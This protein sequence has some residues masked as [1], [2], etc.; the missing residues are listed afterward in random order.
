METR[1]P[2][3]S[4]SDVQ[5]ILTEICHWKIH[6]I[7]RLDSFEDRNFMVKYENAEASQSKEELK[8]MVK[9]VHSKNFCQQKVEAERRVMDHLKNEGF[10]CTS[11]LS[12]PDGKWHYHTGKKINILKLT[13]LLS[14]SFH[15]NVLTHFFIIFTDDGKHVFRLFSFIPGVTLKSC[16]HL[17]DSKSMLLD[18][19]SFVGKLHRSLQVYSSVKLIV[20][21]LPTT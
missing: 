16:L 17:I 8:A 11:C 20:V 14:T 6:K 21:T 9:I 18:L 12:F 5:H 10:I 4:I 7:D 13:S 19:G 15:T 2:D 3:I 1:R